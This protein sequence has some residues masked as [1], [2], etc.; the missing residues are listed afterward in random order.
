MTEQKSFVL[1]FTGLSQAGKTTVATRVCEILERKDLKLERLDGD[2][3]R[4]SL[5]ADLG[6][7]KQDRD[8]NIKRVMYVA[9]YL[10]A[11]GTRVICSF[12]SPYRKMRGEVR[13]KVTNFI[14]VFCNC[15]LQVCERR[16]TKGLYQKARRGE[17]Q[18]FTGVSDPYELPQNPEIELHTDKE[19]IAE[20]V[21][22]VID[23][24]KTNKFI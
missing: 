6:F 2:I 5:S 16:D 24:L 9:K 3:V 15:P 18:N 20:S 14:E 8:E 11:N 7:S 21:S 13:R 22:K 1:W 23:Y 19:T 12:I 17:I 10:S 4:R